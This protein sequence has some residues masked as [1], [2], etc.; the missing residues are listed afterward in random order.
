MTPPI[1]FSVM[2]MSDRC[3]NGEAE[4]LSGPALVRLLTES[5]A[6]ECVCTAL[7]PDEADRIEALLREWV[8][9]ADAPDLIVTTG[10]TGLSP[11]DVTPE[12]TANVIERRHDAL[13]ELARARCYAIT[14]LACLSRGIAGTA[15][16][17]LIINLPGSPRGATET[18]EAILEVLP[19]AI[20]TLRGKVMSK[21]DH[22]TGPV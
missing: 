15:G 20:E 13:L 10:G 14:P 12:A 6:G 11:R 16:R 3:S 19:H 7:V 2:T 4:D 1:R 22:R 17:T 9:R 5:V 18:L 21:N 8:G